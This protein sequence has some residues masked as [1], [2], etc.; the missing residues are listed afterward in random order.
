MKTLRGLVNSDHQTADVLGADTD[1][2]AVN[3]AL[4]FHLL[5][6]TFAAEGNVVTI[7]RTG[8]LIFDETR[9]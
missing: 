1:A 3:S 2:R 5:G 8:E 6:G 9:P 4:L 7:T